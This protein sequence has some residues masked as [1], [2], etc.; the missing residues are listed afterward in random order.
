MPLGFDS[1]LSK[2]SESLSSTNDE[3]SWSPILVAEEN[4]DAPGVLSVMLPAI[5]SS[6][7][8]TV[9]KTGTEPVAESVEAIRNELENSFAKS[10]VLPLPKTLEI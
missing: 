7:I 3:E 4:I 1:D 5:L 8:R 9:Y 6:R 2:L 10:E